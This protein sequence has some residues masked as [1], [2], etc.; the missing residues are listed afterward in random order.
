V[1]RLGRVLINGKSAITSDCCLVGG[2]SGG[3]LFDMH[4][5]VIGIHSRIGGSITA[6][7]HVPVDTYRDTWDRLAKG[8]AFGGPTTSDAYL[9]IQADPDAKNCLVSSVQA[10]SP[11]EK[12][13]MKPMD[14]IVK[15][16]GQKVEAFDDLG[17]LIRK[18]KPGDEV[19]VEI[20]RGDETVTL[21]VVLGRRPAN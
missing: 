16:D 4:G 19:A 2:D 11:A 13:G 17:A 12:A 1:V 18:K 21:K 8:E 6:N 9:G 20:R 3:P 7:V 14:I 5:R 10:G 15:F